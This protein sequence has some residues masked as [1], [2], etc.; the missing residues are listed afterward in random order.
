M[1]VICNIINV[2]VIIMC[3]LILMCININDVCND[4]IIIINVYYYY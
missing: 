2:Y 4:N 3:V 1:C